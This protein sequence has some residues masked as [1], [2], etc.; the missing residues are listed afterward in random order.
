MTPP[1]AP[2]MAPAAATPMTIYEL[3]NDGKI[4]VFASIDDMQ[5][6]QNGKKQPIEMAK[7]QFTAKG[8]DVVFEAADDAQASQMLAAYLKLHPP[9]AK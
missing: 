1:A 2:A 4:F 8:T 3:G 9:I 5:S 6:F 7:P